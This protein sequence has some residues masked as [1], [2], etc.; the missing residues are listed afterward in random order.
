MTAWAEL[1]KTVPHTSL[2]ETKYELQWERAVRALIHRQCWHFY[3][4][5]FVTQHF[6]FSNNFIWPKQYIRVI[7]LSH[8][9]CTY[10]GLQTPL[11]KVQPNIVNEGDEVMAT[12]STPEETGGLLIYFYKNNLE[13]QRIHNTN[14]S[15]T[16]NVKVQESGNISLHCKYML[17]LHP[18]AGHSSNS[19]TVNVIVQGKNSQTQVISAIWFYCKTIECSHVGHSWMTVMQMNFKHWVLSTTGTIFHCIFP[20][21]FQNLR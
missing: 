18:T 2:I 21:S 16:I 1:K 9:F 3:F 12:C 20:F 19:N 4:S 10:T 6:H 15:A 11:L 13:L 14:N 17:M 5:V 7:G 8:K